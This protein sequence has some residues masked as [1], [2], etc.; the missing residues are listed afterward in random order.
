MRPLSVGALKSSVMVSDI[1]GTSVCQYFHR[2]VIFCDGFV[3]CAGVYGDDALLPSGPFES[4]IP[5]AL[6]PIKS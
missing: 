5:R 4:L 2:P 6:T 1:L 3:I